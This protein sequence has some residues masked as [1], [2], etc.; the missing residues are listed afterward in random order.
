MI[1][2]YTSDCVHCGFCLPTCPTYLLWRE[3]MDSPRGRIHLMDAL[4]K[5]E[6][7]HAVRVVHHERHVVVGADLGV[8]GRLVE[9]DGEVVQRIRARH[10]GSSKRT[11][12]PVSSIGVAPLPRSQSMVFCPSSFWNAGR[13]TIACVAPAATSASIIGMKM[14]SSI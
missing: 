4:A 3:E 7:A 9:F 1:R 8:G 6:D 5:G 13:W 2:E 12:C 14:K 11:D 10:R